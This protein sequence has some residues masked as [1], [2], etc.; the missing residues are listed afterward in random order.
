MR[1][2]ERRKER[3]KE[4]NPWIK[5]SEREKERVERSGESHAHAGHE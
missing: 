1:K 4:E 2:G 5:A 3:K